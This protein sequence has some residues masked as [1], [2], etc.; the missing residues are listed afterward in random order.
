MSRREL[1]K[2]LSSV[3]FL[4]EEVMVLTSGS[5]VFQPGQNIR[6]TSDVMEKCEKKKILFIKANQI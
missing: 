2:F 4:S 5:L 3:I 6:Q 1:T